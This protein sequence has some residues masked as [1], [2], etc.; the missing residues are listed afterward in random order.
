MSGFEM[1]AAKLL[2]AS[3]VLRPL[4]YYEKDGEEKPGKKGESEEE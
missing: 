2:A 1:A 4:Q 3:N